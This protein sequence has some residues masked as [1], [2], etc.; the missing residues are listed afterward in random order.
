[1]KFI[2]MSASFFA[3]GVTD[4]PSYLLVKEI[5]IFLKIKGEGRIKCFENKGR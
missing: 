1:M 4:M 5:N 3:H 2:S